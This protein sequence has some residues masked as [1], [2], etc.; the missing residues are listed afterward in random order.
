LCQET[1]TDDCASELPG[2]L[3]QLAAKVAVILSAIRGQAGYRGQVIIV[4]YYSLN[5]ANA[6]DNEQSQ[7]LNEAVDT[8]A[9][10]FHVQIADGYGAFQAAA[11]GSGG[12]SCT[13]G[14]LTQLSGGGCG[15]HPS[16]AGQAVL[17]L[18]VEEAMRTHSHSS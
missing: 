12:N 18:A 13:A 16:V 11:L 15:V 1:T 14:L 5:Y 9:V 2:V 7:L 4:N 3:K 8:T 10:P 17:A 6:V